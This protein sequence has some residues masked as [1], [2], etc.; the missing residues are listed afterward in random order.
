MGKKAQNISLIVFY[1]DYMLKY[2]FEYTGLN[3]FFTWL[4]DNLK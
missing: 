1:M 2:K 4:L 3:T